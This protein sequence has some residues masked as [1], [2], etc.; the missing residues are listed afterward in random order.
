MKIALTKKNYNAKRRE[1]QIQKHHFLKEI[2][3]EKAPRETP[4]PLSP[5]T[6]PFPSCESPATC[7]DETYRGSR[8]PNSRI[9]RQMARKKRTSQQIIFNKVREKREQEKDDPLVYIPNEHP[10]TYP[11]K[12]IQNIL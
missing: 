12:F 8:R 1:K 7:K 5:S 10:N 11:R 3:V 6:P 2:K 4:P 9:R